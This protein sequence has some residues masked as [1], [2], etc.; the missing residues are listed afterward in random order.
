MTARLELRYGAAE[1]SSEETRTFH[2]LSHSRHSLRQILFTSITQQCL[3]QSNPTKQAKRGTEKQIG[4]HTQEKIKVANTPLPSL[5]SGVDP[6]S[7]QSA[8]R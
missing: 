5:D 4:K 7:W 8:C 6:G 3:I 1:E 2:I